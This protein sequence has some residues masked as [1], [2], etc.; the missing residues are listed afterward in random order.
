MSS[1]TPIEF[2]VFT[3]PWKAPLAELGKLV[4]SWGFDGIELPV[5]PGYQVQP[6]AV[7][8]DL[9]RA[10]RQLAGD[11]VK[12]FSIAGPTDEAAIAACAAFV[13]FSALA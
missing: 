4:K 9:P 2:S 13:S 3:K 8:R 5:R 1:N 7:A 12:V 6:E 10:V 11:G